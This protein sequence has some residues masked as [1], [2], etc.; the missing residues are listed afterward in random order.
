M[1]MQYL[2]PDM[3][4][5]F[6]SALGLDRSKTQSAIGAAVPG[7]L[8][9]FS[10]LAARP[11]G[12]QRLADAVRGQD[13]VLGRYSSALGGLGQS[14]LIEKG[15]Q[16][17]SSLLGT[18][19]EAALAGAVGSYAGVNR[20]TSDSLL[21]M[22]TPVVMGTIAQQQGGHDIDARGISG[23]FASQKDAIVAAMPSGFGNLLSGTG[24]LDSLGGA[25]RTAGSQTAQAASSA[26]YAMGDAGRRTV[27]AAAR[28]SSNWMFWL[29]P[30]AALALLFSFLMRERP[31][32]SL[33]PTSVQQ[34]ILTVSGMDIRNIVT[35]GM[36]DLR[37]T[38]GGITDV[39]S[40]Q[41]ALPRLQ[42]IST[43]ID[44]VADVK[45][46]LTTAQRT[47]LGGL[48]G[49]SMQ[50]LRDLS[51]K[52]LAVPGVSEIIKPTVDSL[53]TKIAGLSV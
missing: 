52:V 10:S 50:G 21:G 18:R 26:A 32:V 7:L 42:A 36:S 1:I 12:A 20:G 44:R 38:L 29:I 30:L 5:R 13:D 3:I 37:T 40:A 23:F 22:L 16:M 11:D 4:S 33:T 51:N 27:N 39:A 17:L 45:G 28:S 19:D 9:G 53:I 49:P 8:A 25:M 2:T 31:Q 15:T 47:A 43:Q 41:A 35:T 24:L 34:P 14:S 48:T 46:S 6:A